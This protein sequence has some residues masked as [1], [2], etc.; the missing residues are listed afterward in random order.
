MLVF[1]MKNQV[2]YT[3]YET[4]SAIENCKSRKTSQKNLINICKMLVFIMKNQVVY[5]YYETVS[6]IENC[7]SR[8]TSQK[9]LI[10]IC[11]ESWEKYGWTVEVI[12][13]KDAQNHFLYKEYKSII[14]TF[15]SVNP[16]PY[17]YHC[18]M[19]WLAM[20][21]I[22]GGIMIDYDVMNTGL[23]DLNFFNFSELTVYQ[24]HV[25]CVVSGKAEDYLSAVYGFMSF[26]NNIGI[27][28][29]MRNEPHT[30]DMLMLS[31]GKIK[32]K[33]MNEVKDYP[34]NGKL[35]HCSQDK[36]KNKTKLEIMK[37]LQDAQSIRFDP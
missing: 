16:F 27:D 21:N 23:R 26:K 32:F 31:S 10:N 12:G 36:C 20:A 5:T 35:I 11:S 17:D 28:M 2:V 14:L 33:K 15:P 19:R 37:E 25:P 1:I 34:E 24:G 6:A 3:Y 7:K 4:V 22:G 8:K 29:K 13:E 18:Y 9:N 30:S